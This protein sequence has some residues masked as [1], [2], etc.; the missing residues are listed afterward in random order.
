MRQ[1][2]K[3]TLLATFPASLAP[4]GLS[5]E[6]AAVYIG[7]SPAKFDQLVDDGRMPKPKVVDGRRIFDRH[8]LDIAFDA[9]PDT[10]GNAY[11]PDD[12]WGRAAL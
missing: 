7:V 5:R 1:K 11:H 2:S 12:V 10:D 4:R 9:L 3:A 6:H 8:Q